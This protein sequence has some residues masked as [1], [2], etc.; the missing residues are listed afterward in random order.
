[1]VFRCRNPKIK[2]LELNALLHG[3]YGCAKELHVDFQVELLGNFIIANIL[4]KRYQ[5]Y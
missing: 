4:D 5:I 2:L 3:A 1:M